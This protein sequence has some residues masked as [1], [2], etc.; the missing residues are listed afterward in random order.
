MLLRVGDARRRGERV[1][2]ALV[3]DLVAVV[4]RVRSVLGATVAD[5][6][7]AEPLGDGLDDG[8]SH[9]ADALPDADG[10][11]VVLVAAVPDAVPDG[12]APGLREAE[13]VAAALAVCDGDTVRAAVPLIVPLADAA[14][15]R[16]GVG[17]DER[18][19]VAA[20][21]D[22]DAGEPD[23]VG[24]AGGTATFSTE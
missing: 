4:T 19:R 3:L 13:A 2:R 18:E 6:A 11:L 14:A 15:E 22:V 24:S 9:E 5:A 16:L 7:G 23:A 10:E 21:D 20:A 8:G 1:R 17:A 12:E